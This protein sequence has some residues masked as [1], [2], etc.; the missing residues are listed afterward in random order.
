[1]LITTHMDR[2]R[3]EILTTYDQYMAMECREKTLRTQNRHQ[4][5]QTTTC[6]ALDMVFHLEITLYVG[7]IIINSQECMNSY[8][9]WL[10]F[11]ALLVHILPFSIAHL[12]YHVTLSLLVLICETRIRSRFWMKWTDE[13]PTVVWIL[14]HKQIGEILKNPELLIPYLNRLIQTRLKSSISAYR[15]VGVQVFLQY[16]GDTTP[17]ASYL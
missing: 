13:Q 3:W 16:V 17:P 15:W 14:W 2:I 4:V 1:M 10:H 9:P 6:F 5:Q 8:S 12:V 7:L 11:S